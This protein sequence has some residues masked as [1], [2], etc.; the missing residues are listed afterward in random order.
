MARTT[1]LRWTADNT[2]SLCRCEFRGKSSQSKLLDTAR[3]SISPAK[4][5]HTQ[6]L[7]EA[8]CSTY[9]SLQAT[10]NTSLRPGERAL[11]PRELDEL[12]FAT[13]A[14]CSST[15]ITHQ[16]NGAWALCPGH[17][18]CSASC[19]DHIADATSVSPAMLAAMVRGDSISSIP[20]DIAAT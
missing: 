16:I 3:S 9:Y 6:L 18:R 13:P 11:Q 20:H 15:R 14:P 4:P 5:F 10:G 8:C 1:R 12:L 2:Q 19:R 17:L 7:A